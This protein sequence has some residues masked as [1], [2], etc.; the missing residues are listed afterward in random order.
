[1]QAFSQLASRAALLLRDDVDTDQIFPARYLTAT[2]R[3]GMREPLFADWRADPAF[4]LNQPEAQGCAI[5]V[6]GRNFG[7][8]SSREHAVWALQGWDFRAVIAASFGDIFYSNALKNGL[9]PVQVD[10]PLLRAA[11]PAVGVTRADLHIDLSAQTLILP[12]GQPVHFQIDPFSKRC[13]LEGLDP[14]G[15]LLRYEA[16]IAAFEAGRGER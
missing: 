10:E 14:L 9:L 1:M 5:L 2:T 3:Q 13:L 6:A 12:D 16:E 7:S 15:Y 8:G 4:L 11:F